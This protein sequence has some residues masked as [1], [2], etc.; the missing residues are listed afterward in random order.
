MLRQSYAEFIFDNSVMVVFTKNGSGWQLKK[1][2]TL[3]FEH[4]ENPSEINAVIPDRGQSVGFYY[5]FNNTERE[6]L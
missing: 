4:I 3:V 6:D 1:K 2:E 5:V